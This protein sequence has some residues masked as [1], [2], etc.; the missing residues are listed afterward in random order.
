[1]DYVPNSAIVMATGLLILIWV[2]LVYMVFSQARDAH[3]QFLLD[4]VGAREGRS[5]SPAPS[6]SPPR[7]PDDKCI[8]EGQRTE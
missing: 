4:L 5:E 8:Q 6:G 2:L 3:L 7:L 1:M